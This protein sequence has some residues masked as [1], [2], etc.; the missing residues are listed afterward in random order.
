LLVCY[1]DKSSMALTPEPVPYKIYLRNL[2]PWPNKLVRFNNTAWEQWTDGDGT[3]YIDRA[4]SCECKLLM[5]PIW[6]N[7]CEHKMCS[8]PSGRLPTWL[9]KIATVLLSQTR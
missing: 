4:I 1:K 8:T 2:Q 9:T 3:T 7:P 6:S 5:K